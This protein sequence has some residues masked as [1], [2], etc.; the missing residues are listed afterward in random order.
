ME[1]T[2]GL[3][4]KR[5]KNGN[6]GVGAGYVA[7]GV[8]EILRLVSQCVFNTNP[9]FASECAK[10]F[11]TPVRGVYRRMGRSPRERGGGGMGT[12]RSTGVCF[13]LLPRCPA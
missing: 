3:V 12:S 8:G 6:A 4:W 7:A 13:F 2:R 1:T 9:G 11:D 10:A 5:L